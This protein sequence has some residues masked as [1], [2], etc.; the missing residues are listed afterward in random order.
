[1]LWLYSL[2]LYCLTPFVLMRLLWRSFWLPEYRYRIAERFAMRGA[3]LSAQPLIWIHAVSVGETQAAIPLVHAL[4]RDY[5]GIQILFTTT[6]PTGSERVRNSLGSLVMHRYAPYDLPDVIRRFLNQFRPRLVIILE[7]ELWPNLIHSCKRRG[8]PIILA[9]ARLS[10]NSLRGYQYLLP[11]ARSTV[12]QFNV[13]AAQSASD[14]QRL[15]LLGALPEQLFITGNLKFEL[16]IP[17]HIEY[18]AEKL[19]ALFGKDRQVWIAASTHKY[20]E[21]LIL[22]AHRIIR[23]THPD[24]LLILVPRHPERFAEVGELC[25]KMNFFVHPWSAQ[26]PIPAEGAVYLGDTMGHLLLFY[27]AADAAFIGGS[28]V[29][30]GGHNPLEPAALGIPITFGPYY[31]NFYDIYQL[32]S[33]AEGAYQVEDEQKLAATITNWFDHPDL[34]RKIG[35]QARQVVE[36]QRGALTKLKKIIADQITPHI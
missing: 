24:A 36:L 31:A 19:R 2:I 34:R 10:I 29:K 4:R 13:I 7:T 1:M 5:P 25:R 6:T 3:I 15:Q 18:D 11:L 9:N 14:A 30:H 26:T 12:R 33:L 20:E 22:N 23:Q 17:A 32:L 27:A 28:L 8:I 16:E 21:I 35:R